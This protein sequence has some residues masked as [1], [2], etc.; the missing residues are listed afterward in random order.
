MAKELAGRKIRVNTV[1]FGMIR[2]EMYDGFLAQGGDTSVWNDQYLGIGEP[3][4]AANAIA[5]LLS[6]AAKFITGTGLI[7]D[8]GYLS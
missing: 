5:F 7:V 2:T 3:I 1:L 8:G 4:D 6:D